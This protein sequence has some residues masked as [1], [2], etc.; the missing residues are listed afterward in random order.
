MR[1]ILVNQSDAVPAKNSACWKRYGEL[2]CAQYASAERMRFHL[3]IVDSYAAQHPGG[4]ERRAIQSVGIHLMTL[5]LFLHE[6]G[7]A[8]GGGEMSVAVFTG[9]KTH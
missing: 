6:S 8:E 3:L 4:N 5:C 2:L 9:N 7:P 1:C